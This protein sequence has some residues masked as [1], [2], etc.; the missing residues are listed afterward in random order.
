MFIRE[1]R[2]KVNCLCDIMF[3]YKCELESKTRTR[4]VSGYNQKH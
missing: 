2:R 4:A 1:N 3:E